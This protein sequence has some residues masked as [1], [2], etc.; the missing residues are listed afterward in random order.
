MRNPRF[1]DRLTRVNL[2]VASKHGQAD[3][4]C[5]DVFNYCTPEL[6]II[7][8]RDRFATTVVSKYERH[9]RA[10][11]KTLEQPRILTTH[12]AGTIAI[13]Q[14]SSNSIRVITQRAKTYQLQQTEV[15]QA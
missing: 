1:R 12:H 7:S 6:I 3:G 10:V 11:Q 14:S 9:I 15:Y 8:N 2:F 5:S 4:Y 13:Q